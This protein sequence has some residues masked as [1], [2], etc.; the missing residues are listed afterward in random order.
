M[1]KLTFSTPEGKFCYG[2]LAL[3]GHNAVCKFFRE[4]LKDED[5]NDIRCLK[6]EKCKELGR[7]GSAK[8][9]E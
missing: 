8:S 6:C 4:F 1:A 2:C 3:N 7:S 5:G 9:E